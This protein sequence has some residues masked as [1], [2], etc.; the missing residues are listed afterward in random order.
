MNLK[1]ENAEVDFPFKF[2]IFIN[3]SEIALAVTF[4]ARTGKVPLWIEAVFN[5]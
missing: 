2:A 4:V 5:H 3:H 1:R